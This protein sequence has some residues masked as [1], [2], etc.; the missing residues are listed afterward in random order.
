MFAKTTCQWRFGQKNGSE[1]R[2]RCHSAASWPAPNCGIQGPKR[3]ETRIATPI[4]TFKSLA[5]F[6]FHVQFSSWTVPLLLLVSLT[7][8]RSGGQLSPDQ[9]GWARLRCVAEWSRRSVANHAR[10]TRVG[11][12]P[13]FGTTNH[14]PTVNSAVHP[15]EVCKWELRSNSEGTSTGHTLIT[16]NLQSTQLS[17][18]PRLANAYSEVTLSAQALDTHW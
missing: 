7:V 6:S 10:S 18:L 8:V 13:F 17:I 12:N 4:F 15:S 1:K 11:S 3:Q 2:T 16:A 5:I 14:K 9:L